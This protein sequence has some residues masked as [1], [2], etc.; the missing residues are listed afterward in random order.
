[1][2]IITLSTLAAAVLALLPVS[3]AAQTAVLQRCD[4]P[5]A[6]AEQI[7][8][9]IT[10][11][12]SALAAQRAALAAVKGTTIGPQEVVQTSTTP[13]TPDLTRAAMT[14]P[15]LGRLVAYYAYSAFAAGDP[16]QCSALSPIGP[17]PVALCRRMVADLDFV[18]ARYGSDADLGGACRRTDNESGPGAA[19]CCTALTQA[20]KGANPCATMSPK[21]LDAG[22][23]KAIFGSWNGDAASCRSLPM[24]EAGD[25]KGPD[26]A[27]IHAE[28][29]ASCEAD[30]AFAR[31]YKAKSA[32]EC[33]ASE[34]CRALMG[35]GKAVAQ[36]I[37][38]KDMKN[39]VGAWF[40]QS[41]WKVPSVQVRTRAPI[42][43]APATPTTAVKA[44]DFKG[45]TCAEP[46]FSKENR[47]AAAALVASAR[48]C[49]GDVEAATSVPSKALADAI[50]AREE[51]LIR[52]SLRVDKLFE[53]GK[54]AKS[55]APAPR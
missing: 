37:A 38:A 7:S 3:A 24:P 46:L 41:A 40:L 18:R 30:A 13:M 36:A 12:A 35:A 47:Q 9:A 51:Q 10:D 11:C 43:A 1:M 5:I 22:S 39:P 28:R 44:L 55:A 14:E 33:G 53:G 34:R 4:K 48:T 16:A 8:K 20:R 32:A 21:C 52:A 19:A 25:C 27:R 49:L 45:F 29:V 50:D 42:K 6:E 15:L 54:P 17:G 31:A 2:K 23:C 26:C